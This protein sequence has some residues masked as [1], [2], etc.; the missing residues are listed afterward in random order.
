MVKLRHKFPNY[1]NKIV[2][3]LQKEYPNGLS[4]VPTGLQ[5]IDYYLPDH[6]LCIEI[7]GSFHYYGLTEQELAKTVL[8]YRLYK[9]ANLNVL[10]LKHF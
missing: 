8:K 5:S 7:D 9:K 4:E 3:W 1:E 2:E 6:N 10:R